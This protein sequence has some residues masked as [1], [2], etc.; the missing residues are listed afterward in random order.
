MLLRI[1]SKIY[2][3]FFSAVS[4]GKFLNSFGF[5]EIIFNSLSVVS[6]FFKSSY[7]VGVGDFSF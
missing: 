1:F 3:N 4:H 2:S 5:D 6:E 7:V